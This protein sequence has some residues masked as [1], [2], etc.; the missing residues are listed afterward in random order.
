MERLKKKKKKIPQRRRTEP[1]YTSLC[2][3]FAS[4]PQPLRFRTT[5]APL[6]HRMNGMI[7]LPILTLS[8][9][10][11]IVSSLHFL[12]GCQSPP[13]PLRDNSTSN[14]SNDDPLLL[15]RPSRLMLLQK[16]K[17]RLAK[18]SKLRTVGSVC[19]IS[20]KH[21]SNEMN[22]SPPPPQQKQNN[23]NNNQQT[24]T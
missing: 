8:V 1:S 6:P 23:K 19:T 21:S 3:I 9:A 22:Y 20:V 7:L 24:R 14:K 13:A 11:G 17:R 18:R 4:A 16:N 10:L 5:T 2:S 12:L 15:Y